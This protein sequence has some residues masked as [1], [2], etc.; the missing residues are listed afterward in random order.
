MMLFF[1]FEPQTALNIFKNTS[2]YL[3]F[4]SESVKQHFLIIN[5]IVT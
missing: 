3:I 1:S 4:D 5:L 2:E